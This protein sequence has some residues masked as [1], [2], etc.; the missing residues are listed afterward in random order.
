MLSKVSEPLARRRGFAIAIPGSDQ[1]MLEYID[2][3][4]EIMGTQQ[5]PRCTYMVS[6]T[7]TR[8]KFLLKGNEDLRLDERLMQFFGLVNTLFVH[9]RSRYDFSIVSYPVV[10]LTKE[11][12]LIKW[13]TGADTMHQM[14][15]EDRNLRNVPL[16]RE[17]EI[18]RELMNCEF[19]TLG[20]LQRME[21]FDE[22]CKECRGL[23]L[24]EYIW[25]KSPNAAIWV[26][27]TERFTISTAVMSMI[28]YIVG[29][30]DRHPSNIMVQ[31]DTGNI[32]HIDFGESFDSALVRP[33]NPERV[34]FRLTRMIVAALE[35]SVT[36]ALYQ[37][38]CEKVMTLI[39][40]HKDALGIQL[41]IFLKERFEICAIQFFKSDD[42]IVQR[43]AEKLDGT[44]MTEN[45]NELTITEQ[46]VK[47][48]KIAANPQNY[49]MHY[50]GWCPFW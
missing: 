7:G 31:K 26:H 24:F 29:L 18:I 42:A 13:V 40:K 3:V 28:G 50:R 16:S 8:V 21:L 37:E 20:C 44:D 43:V 9:S 47:L 17:S 4:L 11:A 27:R 1:G 32:I 10:P 23:D 33:V 15:L 25:L 6:T 36:D 49:M 14:I 38:V 12:G 45:G 30:G 22:V 46:V 34:P 19:K 48:I 2:P 35:G 41:A 39:R 5:H